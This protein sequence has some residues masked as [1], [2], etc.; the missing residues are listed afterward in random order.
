MSQK[1]KNE[2]GE[3]IAVNSKLNTHIP[4]IHLTTIAPWREVGRGL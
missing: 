2:A 4:S 3:S 1:T